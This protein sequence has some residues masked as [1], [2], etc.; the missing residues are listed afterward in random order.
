MSDIRNPAGYASGAGLEL[1]AQPIRRTESAIP[2][3]LAIATA[4]MESFK[5]FEW[6]R[7]ACAFVRAGL[8]ELEHGRVYFGSDNVSIECDGHGIA[9]SVVASLLA[10][11]V[12][13]S[14]YGTHAELG[15]YGGRRKSLRESRN[16]AKVALYQLSSRRIAEVFLL[17]QGEIVEPEQREMFAGGK[18]ACELIQ[19][20]NPQIDA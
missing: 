17:R 9:G 12:I 20:T 5:P 15:I 18:A 3:R 1:F 13:T 6:R 7:Y 14:Y 4:Q 19:E 2:P 10:A 11:N 16:A 8:S